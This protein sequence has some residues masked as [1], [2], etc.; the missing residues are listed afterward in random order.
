MHDM[1][2]THT[3]SADT[4]KKLPLPFFFFFFCSYLIYMF[5]IMWV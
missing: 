2:N 5:I 1:M 3:Q 4:V